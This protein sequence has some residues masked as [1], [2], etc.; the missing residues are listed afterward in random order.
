MLTSIME[1][2]FLDDDQTPLK[3]FL[4]LSKGNWEELLVSEHG[5]LNR[6]ACTQD[7]SMRL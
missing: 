6:V 2:F 3:K 1:P 7:L 5:S 4:T